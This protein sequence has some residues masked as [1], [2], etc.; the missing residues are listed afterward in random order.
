MSKTIA[1]LGASGFLGRRLA[2]RLV[3][4]GFEVTGI[5]RSPTPGINVPGLRFVQATMDDAK[6][7]KPV[8]ERAQYLVHL[9][10]DTT[11]GTSQLQPTLEANNNLLPTL[12]L[13]EQMQG[14]PSCRMVF[15]ST[16]GA[17]Y[18]DLSATP[19]SEDAKLAP[20]SYYGAGK[21]AIESMLS[22]YHAQTGNAVI[23]LRPSNIYGPGQESKRQFAVVPTLMQCLR[24]D[25]EFVIWGDGESRRDYLYIQDFEDVVLKI[26]SRDWPVPLNETFN[27][28]AGIGVPL[29]SICTACEK[30]SGQ[31]L[32]RRYESRRTV[33][34]G[35]VILD[36][37]RVRSLLGWT[38]ETPLETGL[39][40]T[41]K[42]F[43][44]QR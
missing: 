14:F 2:A 39:E 35:S 5:A 3:R 32:R 15:V 10:W 6:A 11:P 21:L 26:I 33:D 43:I 30:I 16:G 38:A 18:S 12:R 4:E 22:A 44:S 19:W 40:A 23:V 7:L 27:V 28:A 42:W 25:R 1:L 29:N 20:R 9:A 36:A 41:W 17:I 31:R 34:K 13:M 37:T 24:D 8:L